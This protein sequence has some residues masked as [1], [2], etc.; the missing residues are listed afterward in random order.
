MKRL[1]INLKAGEEFHRGECACGS[2]TAMYL[3]WITPKKGL[4]RRL[5]TCR[6]CKNSILVRYESI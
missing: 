6:E 2:Y 3:E 4:L 1:V 5:I